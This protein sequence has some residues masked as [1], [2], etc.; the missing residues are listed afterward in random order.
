MDRL[1]L[2]KYAAT[3]VLLLGATING[4]GLYPLGPVMLTIGSAMWLA[5][6]IMWKETSLI[7]T[8]FAM[9]VAGLVGLIY[10]Y[11]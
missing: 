2:L 3:A 5:A 1:E 4:F 10:N 9:T 6:S 7:V 11:I 8:N